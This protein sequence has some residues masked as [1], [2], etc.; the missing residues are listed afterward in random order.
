ME[1]KLGIEIAYYHK[2]M[3][4]NTKMKEVIREV[5]NRKKSVNGW[6]EYFHSGDLIKL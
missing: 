1:K 5:S 4:C 3:F 2:M 6:S